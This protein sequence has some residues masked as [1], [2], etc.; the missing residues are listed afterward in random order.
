M[1]TL[2]EAAGAQIGQFIERRRA[3]QRVAESEALYS[4][5]VNAALDCVVTI[6][7][8]GRIVEFNP[9]ATRVFGFSR[10]EA[11]GRELAD[12]DRAGAI[13][14]SPSR[15]RWRGMSKPARR[16]FS[17]NGSKCR[18]CAPTAQNSSWRSRSLALAEPANR[19]S[20]HTCAT[21]PT[22]SGRE[23]ARTAAGA[24]AD[25]RMDAEAANRSKDQFLATVSHEL[26]TPLTAILGWASMLKTRTFDPERTRQIYD[27]LERNAHAQAQIVGDLLDV[28][29]IVTGQLRLESE[30]FDVCDVANLSLETI[31]PT[32]VAKDVT[33][34]SDIRL[35]TCL[36][37]RRSGTAAAGHLE[38][39]VECRQIHLRP[40]ARSR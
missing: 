19:S 32:A 5:I 11:L 36:V 14:R 8:R 34:L 26:R 29:R 3:E 18:R 27:S 17:A 13:A 12:A 35:A 38:P 25:R 28:S 6:D 4:A 39:V 20:P 37:V 7:S 2:M 15:P 40:A 22:A 16:G 33:L 1:L 10:S 21:L 24:R 31:R 9:A 30:T 23:R